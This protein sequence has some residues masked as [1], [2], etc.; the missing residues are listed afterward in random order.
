MNHRLSSVFPCD[1]ILKYDD[2]QWPK[3]NSLHEKLVNKCKNKNIILGGRGYFVNKSFRCYKPNNFTENEKGIVVDHMATPFLTRPGYLKLDA[4]YK[5]YSLYHAEDVSLS[6]NSW[7]SC[8]VISIYQELKI[9]QNHYDGNNKDLDE[10]NKLIY[11]KEKDVF[12]NSYQFL[13][14][15]GYNTKK[16]NETNNSKNKAI[17]ITISHKPLYINHN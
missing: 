7:K 5:I 9:I 17:N 1:F 15:S 6:V 16:W 11:Q 3:D 2:D 8:N 4:R 14:K 13:I 12:E 10:K